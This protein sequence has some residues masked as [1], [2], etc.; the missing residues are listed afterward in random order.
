MFGNTNAPWQLETRL[1]NLLEDKN[2]TVAKLTGELKNMLSNKSHTAKVCGASRG[3]K[4]RVIGTT[5]LNNKQSMSCK[6][7]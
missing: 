1:T 5:L 2:L 4:F 3:L 6:K 7:G